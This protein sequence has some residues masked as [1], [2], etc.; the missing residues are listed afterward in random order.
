MMPEINTYIHVHTCRFHLGPATHS[1]HINIRSSHN[2]L[3]LNAVDHM[4]A[5]VEVENDNI[6]IVPRIFQQLV[7][8]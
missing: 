6:R 4:D 5:V 1:I 7:M 2:N 8:K 3:R